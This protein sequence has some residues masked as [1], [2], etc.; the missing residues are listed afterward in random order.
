MSGANSGSAAVTVVL[1]AKDKEPRSNAPARAAG[2]LDGIGEILDTLEYGPAPESASSV[3]KW[4]DDHKRKFGFFRNNE[5]VIP[6]DREYYESRNPCNL[7]K[8]ADVIEPNQEDVN[9]CVA[10][11]RAAFPKW[12]ALSGHERARYLY[13]L[14]RNIQKHHR[15]LAVLESLDN[16]KTV[17]ESRDVD[18]PLVARHFYYYAGWA[19]LMRSDAELRDY[20]PVGVIGQII[21]WNFPLLMLAWKIA[22]ALAMGN[23]VVLKTATY[24][25][26]SALLFC[27]IVAESGIPPGVVNILPGHANPGAW[28]AAHPDIDKLA[29]TGSGGVGKILR[30]VTAGTGK[31]L[32]LELGGKSPMIVYDTA[33]LDAAVEGVVD[34]IWFN[35]GQVCCAGSRL[36][37]QE[38]V[39]DRF[40]GKLKERMS[41]LRLGD[42]LDKS[43]DMG[44]LVDPIQ[45]RTVSNYLRIAAEEGGDVFQ[46]PIPLPE[47]GVYIRPT[48]ITNVEPVARCVQEEIF[49]P[50]VVAM[51][52][53]SPV[54]AIAIANQTRFGLAASVWT[55]SLSVALDSAFS[56]KAGVVWINSHNVFDA[57][58]GFGGY[59]ESGFGREGGKEGLWEYVRHKHEA[60]PRPQLSDAEK[61]AGWG[62]SI[63]PGPLDPSHTSPERNSA[64][65]ID[66]TYKV[67]IGGVQKRPDGAYSRPI[68]SPDGHLL[69]E[70]AEG[71]RKD[72][73]DAVEAAFAAAP[74]WGKRAAHNRAQICYYIA[75]N[76]DARFDEFALRIRQQTGCSQE[77][78]VEEVRLSIE[79][80]FYWAAYADKYGGVVQET[81]LYGGTVQINEPTGTIGI[82]CPD[83]YPLLGFISLVAPALV[84]G[85]TV[86]AVPS[87]TFPLSVADLYQVFETSDLPGG[88]VNIVTGHCDT[89]AKVMVQHMRLDAVWYF[90]TAVGS[91]HVEKLSACNMKRTWVNYGIERDWKSEEQ[92]QGLEFLHQA[93]QV[94]N[95]WTPAGF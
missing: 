21:P 72:I 3:D 59:R 84:R 39:Y 95:I 4:L 62:S 5:W 31:K 47:N 60:R 77:Q 34:A 54:E 52:F 74:G 88:V 67:Y 29:F 20:Q 12:S 93:T 87:Q 22:P 13:A 70:V 51:S 32:S 24:T 69:G 45:Y 15:M 80:L 85:N 64:R 83:E 10:A 71:N 36:L 79:R 8:L 76:L 92:G 65:H 50:V 53:R 42:S 78:A 7:K 25:R 90:G 37:V 11:A 73:R 41:R 30:E 35:Q 44:P 58:G 33:D 17:R 43:V 27:E 75:E 86:V 55:D 48:L 63:P 94:K 89:L 28:L 16:G 40:I 26:L 66:R 61:A 1:P 57:A 49:G 82:T 91:Y 18:V 68:C 81:P 2:P 14:A 46:A 56:I 19:Q 9:S 38:S 6:A 23:T